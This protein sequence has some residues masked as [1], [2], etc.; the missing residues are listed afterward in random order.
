MNLPTVKQLR[1]FISLDSHEHFGNAAAACFVSQSAFSTAIR[2]LES[3]LDVQLVD[4]T[5]KNVTITH[6]G[7][8]IAIEARRC[9]R[10]I[11]NL[12]ELARSNQ[13][14][15]TGE[16]RIGVIPTIAPFLLPKVLPAMRQAFP[17]LKLLLTEDIT[18]RLH[19]KL[20]AGELD[21]ILL[22]LPYALSNVE[23]LP[24]MKDPFY[25]ACR[26]DSKH[27]EPHTYRFEDLA[28]ESILLLEDGHCLRDHTLSACQVQD[29]DKVNRFTASSVLTL[30]QMVDADLGVT[31]LPKMV[32]DS[33]TLAG[34]E[35]E[36]FPLTHEV[37][38]R[39]IGLAWRR[40]SAREDEFKQLGELI[41]NY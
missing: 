37:S 3:T 6:I 39:E 19:E 4:R 9:I 21:L 27:V 1:Y 35:V 41:Q 26:A 7:R 38:Y 23:V 12:V 15:L 10:D 13:E 30:V 16:L 33:T 20:L 14:P 17:K 11:E 5:N 25:L 40:G 31:F 8:Q 18:Q 36:L 28:P 32:Q 29:L 24:L 22:A 2:E 34:T